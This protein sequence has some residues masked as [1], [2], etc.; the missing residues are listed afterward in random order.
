MHTRL[1]EF[2][3]QYPLK[4]FKKNETLIFQDDQPSEIYYIKSGFVKGYD[5]DSQ[6]TEQL[7]WLG[8]E[9]DFVPLS[10]VFDAEPTV[11]YFFLR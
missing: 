3:R 7:I 6:G 5:I 8:S 11:P 9:G 2:V 4:S 10:W 1:S